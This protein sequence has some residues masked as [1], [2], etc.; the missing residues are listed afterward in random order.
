MGNVNTKVSLSALKS[1]RV[2]LNKGEMMV[3]PPPPP[4]VFVEFV[5][6]GRHSTC[7][8]ADTIASWQ[9]ESKAGEGAAEGTAG[10]GAAEGMEGEGQ[11]ELSG[12]VH[13]D[14]LSAVIEMFWEGPHGPEGHEAKLGRPHRE[15]K[16]EQPVTKLVSQSAKFCRKLSDP[17]NM[18]PIS[19]TLAVEEMF[20]VK[21]LLI[22]ANILHM[23]NKRFVF[24]NTTD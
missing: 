20:T 8:L 4:V 15:Q 7:K 5:S 10:E 23:K 18:P 9:S 6:S 1:S 3:V 17:A 19:I 21:Q 13:M 16:E 22:F 14:T 24:D 12:R 2:I 11:E